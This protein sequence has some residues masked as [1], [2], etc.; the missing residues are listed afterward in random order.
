MMADVRT[1]VRALAEVAET[2]ST[3]FESMFATVDEMRAVVVSLFEAGPVDAARVEAAVH[4]LALDLLGRGH[5][6]GSGFVA[7]PQALSDRDLHLAWWQGDSQQLLGQSAAPAGDPFDYT[8]REWFRVPQATGLRHVTG[9]YVDYVCSDEYVVTSTQPVVAGGRMVGVVGADQLVEVLEDL[10]LGP[11][12]AAG[13]TLVSEHG[14]VIA[15]ADHRLA[16]GTV[17]P[18]DGQVP[19]GT[20]PLAVVSAGIG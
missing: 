9:P 2:I 18:L 6:L 11:L 17:V 19:C 12:S 10:L 20:L 16:P 7:A 13:A 4:P 3:H 1:T 14:R 5:V 8:K 15:S